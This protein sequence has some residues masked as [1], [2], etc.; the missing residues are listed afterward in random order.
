MDHF[1]NASPMTFE[2]SGALR[3]LTVQIFNVPLRPG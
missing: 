3:K 1:P 2:C